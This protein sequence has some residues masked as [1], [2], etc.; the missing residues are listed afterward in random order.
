MMEQRLSTVTC[1]TTARLSAPKGPPLPLRAEL[2]YRVA[3]PYAVRLTLGPSTGPVTTWTFARELLA[4]GLRR[5]VGPGDVMV[6]P[7]Y[8]HH[9]H[10]I[11]IVLSNLD[12]TALIELAAAQV[13]AF[14]QQT[15]ALVPFGTESDHLDVDGAI[16]ALMGRSH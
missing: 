10:S 5:P 15:A 7:R 9:P 2:H 14:L 6:V 13:D 8:C 16:T 4:E 1:Q 3:D 12:G 11:C